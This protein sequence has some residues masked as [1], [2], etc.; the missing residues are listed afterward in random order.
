VF[1]CTRAAYV[2]RLAG[3]W[4]GV[5]MRLVVMTTR[6]DGETS[7]PDTDDV[8][9][10][11]N[12]AVHQS[13]RPHLL[14]TLQRVRISRQNVRNEDCTKRSIQRR[15]WTSSLQLSTTVIRRLTFY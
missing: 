2:V 6:C 9:R 3:A 4:P 10:C 14:H 13:V 8:E 5:M 12:A 11:C 1:S 7:R 15:P